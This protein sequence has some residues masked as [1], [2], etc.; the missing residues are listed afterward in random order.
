MSS[1][2]VRLTFFSSTG[3]V[4]DPS[5][6]SYAPAGSSARGLLD[7]VGDVPGHGAT[8]TAGSWPEIV[9]AA[10]QFGAAPIMGFAGMWV[11]AKTG[12]KVK[13]KMGDVEVEAATAE[14]VDA[15]LRRIA[16]IE[17]TRPATG[18]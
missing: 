8:I 3:Q 2:E 5:T 11:Q 16:E 4:A 7:A 17:R 9:I 6:I 10:A 18:D 13:A 12:R 15:L 14:E 1:E